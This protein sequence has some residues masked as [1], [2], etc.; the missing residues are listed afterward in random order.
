MKLP[1]F[2][3]T[4][5]LHVLVP[6]TADPSGWTV[7]FAGPAHEKTKA[8]SDKA[9]RVASKKEADIE[10]CQVNGRKWKGEEKTPDEKRRETV[11]SIVGRITGWSCADGSAG[12]DFGNGPVAFD[13]DKVVDLFMDPELGAYFSQ[14]VDF[15]VAEKTFLKA[16]AIAS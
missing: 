4:A 7:T 1:V 13:E 12:P 6:G 3:L 5:D 14:F 11:E 2:L 16:S 8:L 9:A 10:R 15:L